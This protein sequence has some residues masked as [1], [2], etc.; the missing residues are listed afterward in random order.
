MSHT[1]HRRGP[2][3]T[4]DGEYIFLCMTA[5]GINEVGSNKAIQEFLTI[6]N[7]YDLAN[8]G[9]MKTGNKFIVDRNEIIGKIQDTSIVQGVFTDKEQAKAALKELK[10]AD[11]GVS[12]V[13]TGIV[14]DV[15]KL[16][17]SVGLK[18]HTVE[19]SL[20][21]HGQTSK[22]PEDDLLEVTTMCGH[23]MVPHR[24]VRKFLVDIK[25]GEITPEQAGEKLATPCV[26][27]IFNPRRAAMLLTRLA[28]LWICDQE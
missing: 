28:E 7:K 18:R 1:L 25:N 26:C 14:D 19:Y 15:H 21:I 6:I 13:V 11:L 22:L 16:C 10:E 12:I 23:G 4:F 9:D 3:E 24:L 20:G 27:G 2:R 5:K 17:Q 8:T